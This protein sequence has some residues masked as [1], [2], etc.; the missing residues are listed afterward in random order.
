MRTLVT[1]ILCLWVDPQADAPALSGSEGPAWEGRVECVRTGRRAHV[2][3]V[4]DLAR[5]IAA[6]TSESM[7]K[8]PHS[9]HEEE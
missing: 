4:T 1:F 9:H 7:T 2:R 6:E 3:D 5:F 8:T